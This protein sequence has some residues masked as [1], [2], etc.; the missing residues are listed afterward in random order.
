MFAKMDGRLPL[1]TLL[2]HLLVAFNIEFDIEAERRMPHRTTRQGAKT[3]S[4][5]TP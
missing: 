1:S 4:L 5:H 3:T 2:S